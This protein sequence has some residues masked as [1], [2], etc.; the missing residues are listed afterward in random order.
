MEGHCL[1]GRSA[2]FLLAFQST[3]SV[4]L[5]DDNSYSRRN[6]LKPSWVTTIQESGNGPGRKKVA[7]TFPRCRCGRDQEQC[8]VAKKRDRAAAT[9]AVIEKVRVSA[10]C[11][12]LEPHAPPHAPFYLL[13]YSYA[14]FFRPLSFL[15]WQCLA[16][17]ERP[18][19]DRGDDAMVSSDE[20]RRAAL[21]IRRRDTDRRH[22]RYR[23]QHI[24]AEHR[25]R[26]RISGGS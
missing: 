2:I 19:H 15:C 10:A 3:K 5:M 6:Q 23:K 17:E 24:A 26:C 12:L 9:L 11:F 8:A 25:R 4:R 7:A 1:S 21:S 22:S 16:H 20:P 14:P 13:P 18:D